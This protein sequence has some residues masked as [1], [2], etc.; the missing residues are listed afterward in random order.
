[1]LTILIYFD[2]VL[3]V[4]SKACISE[5]KKNLKESEKVLDKL[6]KT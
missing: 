2:I 6:L 4:V 5:E 1:M 3:R